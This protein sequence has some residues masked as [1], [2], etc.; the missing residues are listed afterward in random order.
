M[1]QLDMS[2]ILIEFKNVKQF[3]IAA[4]DCQNR[5]STCTLSRSNGIKH[6][7]E[8]IVKHLC[9][10]SEIPRQNRTKNVSP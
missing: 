10:K 7:Y 1:R 9:E 4:K 8:K 5:K 2:V 6:L 3:L